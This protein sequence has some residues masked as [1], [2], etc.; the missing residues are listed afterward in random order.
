MRPPSDLQKILRRRSHYLRHLR[1][2]R[3]KRDLVCELDE[4]RSTIDR[5]V[6]E[7]ERAGFVER[8]DDGYRTTLAGELALTEHDRH[9]DRVRGLASFRDLLAELPADASLDG[10]LFEDPEVVLPTPHSPREPVGAIDAVLADA[11]RAR[12]LG[13]VVVPEFADA[14]SERVLDGG[15]TA[16]FVLTEGVVEWLV[17]RWR[18]QFRA[19]L[20]TDGVTAAVTPTERPF[21][22][23]LVDGREGTEVGVALHVGGSILGFVRNDTAAAVA[24]AEETFERAR[25]GADSLTGRRLDE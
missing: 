18:E 19:F 12:T 20:E 9:A 23:V 25:A 15:M 21:S 24:W 4:S 2:P 1:Q 3:Q 8:G 16:E 13:G 17:S 6:R 7:L 5:A 14:Y 10:S 22:L 11:D